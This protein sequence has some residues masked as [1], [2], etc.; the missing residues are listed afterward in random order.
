MLSKEAQSIKEV[1]GDT[2]E[3]VKALN[4]VQKMT[5]DSGSRYYIAEVQEHMKGL[6]RE[7]LLLQRQNKQ[8]QAKLAKATKAKPVK[9]AKK[10]K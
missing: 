4:T 1:Y 6:Y 9:K 7:A 2:N 10:S 3:L 5:T 8:L